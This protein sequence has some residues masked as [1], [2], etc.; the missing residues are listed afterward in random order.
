MRHDRRLVASPY[1]RRLARERGIELAALAGSGPNGRIVAADLPEEAAAAA[2]V[3]PTPSQMPKASRTTEAPAVRP[4][5]LAV[6]L[7][8]RP[9]AALLASLGDAGFSFDAE[10]VLLLALGRSLGEAP[11]AEASIA[12]ETPGGLRRVVGTATLSALREARLSHHGR[13]VHGVE[14]TL[15]V[16][17][18]DADG[19]RPV[20]LPL[21][22][23]CAMRLIAA[24]AGDRSEADCLLVFDPAAV[25]EAEAVSLLDGVGR[26]VAA[27]LRLL[28]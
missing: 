12:I 17:F 16:R 1:A 28:A 20:M 2:V 23:G 18:M 15:S 7:D 13:D 4:A 6:V 9:V 27:P 25:G 26:S 5:A 22:S 10:D 14:K 19:V 21:T 11:G 3:T 24:L 8:L